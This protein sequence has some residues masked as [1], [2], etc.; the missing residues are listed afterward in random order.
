MQ[1]QD[2]L[3]GTTTICD[4]AWA[5]EFQKLGL[6]LGACADEWNLAKPHLVE[7]VA[8]SYVQ[9]GSRV[10]LTNTFRANAISLTAQGLAGQCEEINRAGVRISRKAAENSA[11][12]FASIGP[13]G[14]LLLTK[15]VT[16]EQLKEAFSQQAKALAS[17]GPDGIV[18]ETFTD[19]AEARIAVAAALKTGLPVIVSFVFDSG[20]NRDR[21]IMG[22]T[23]EQVATTM[24]SDGV[25]AIGAN[26]GLG[27]QEF[28]P[29]CRRL[30]AASRLPIWIKPNAGL[31]EMVGG[32]AKYKTTPAEFAESVPELVDA[33]ATFLGGCCGTT[34]EFIHEIARLPALK[35]SQGKRAASEE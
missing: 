27:I 33:G 30:A 4:G 35:K 11:L 29:V 20:K 17:E 14:K 22:T 5:T 18:L 19:L 3:R 10:I 31:P 26:C 1:F 28:V 8:Q 2:C 16:V 13:S 15:E 23:P 24:T 34:P 32:M 21:T 6:E 25:H 9:A 12:V 7:Q